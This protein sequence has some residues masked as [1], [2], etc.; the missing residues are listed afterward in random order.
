VDDLFEQA[1]A[2]PGHRRPTRRR[3]ASIRGCDCRRLNVGKSTL[4]NA[5]V[6]DERVIAFDQPGT[7]RDPIGRPSSVPAGAT[8]HRH[9]GRAPARQDRH[10]GR[11]LSIV[12]A[13]Q[14]IEA[15]TSRCWCRRADGVTEQDAHVAGTSSSAGAPSSSR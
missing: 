13:L 15:R 5:L 8:R 14:A 10:A 11:V 9:R 3:P 1:A 2:I 6:G 7:T 12:K 4:I